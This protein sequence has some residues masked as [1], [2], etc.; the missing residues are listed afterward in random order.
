[1]NCIIDS[2]IEFLAK[3]GQKPKAIKRYIKMKYR[4]NMDLKSLKQRLRKLDLHPEL[5]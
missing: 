3:S 4:I 2:A 1:M 5:T